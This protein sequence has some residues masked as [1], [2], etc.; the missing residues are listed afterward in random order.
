MR[1]QLKSGDDPFVLSAITPLQKAWARV[2][3]HLDSLPVRFYPHREKII[4]SSAIVPDCLISKVN[5]IQPDIIHLHWTLGGFLRIETLKRIKPTLIW[6]LHDMWPFTGGCHYDD[7]CGRYR[8][9]CGL[10]PILGSKKEWDLSRWTWTRKARAW[11]DMKMVIVTPSRWMAAR[12]RE[13]TLFGQYRIETIPNGVD[14][15]TF[16]LVN[17]TVAREIFSLPPKRKLILFG[18]MSTTDKRKGFD[19]LRLALART[20]GM[21]GKDEW[22]LCIFGTKPATLPDFGLE[23][24][25]FGTLHDDISLAI[26]Y[27]AADVF[28]APSRQDNL[29]N[30]IME[31]LACG[32]PCV[33]FDTGGMPDMIEHQWTGYLAKPF[34]PDDLANGIKWVLQ[35]EQRY[36][37]L[38]RQAREK[39]EAEFS[40]QRISN[41]HIVLYEEHCTTGYK[42]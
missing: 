2:Q 19:V 6:T 5:A 37:F 14:T 40:T 1:V 41:R 35:D 10:C 9:S 7:G 4:Y 17:K 32:T 13:S 25:Y 16:K 22:M 36:G 23:T 21:A 20:M 29:P 18:A 15:N 24:R 38:S 8:A 3:P 39:V 26:L 27:A 31:S 28:V 11:K 42:A 33:A 34:D 12:A 30:T